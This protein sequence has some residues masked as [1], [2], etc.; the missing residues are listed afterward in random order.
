MDREEKIALAAGFRA[1]GWSYQAIGELFGVGGLAIKK[2]LDPDY[3]EHCRELNRRWYKAKYA[4]ER[5]RLVDL[6]KWGE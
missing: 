1:E 4:T 2:W 3:A 5:Q 6:W